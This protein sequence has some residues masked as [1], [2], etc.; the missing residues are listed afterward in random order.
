LTLPPDGLRIAILGA[1]STGKTTLAQA[2]VQRLRDDTGLRVAWIPEYLREWCER[3][4]RTPRPEEQAGIADEQGR[5]IDEAAG[6]H[7]VVLCDT[8]PLMVSVYS[9]FVF[10]DR[11]LHARA[12][13]WHARC[14]LTLV[15]ALD[16]PWQADG[17]QR[18]GPQVRVPVDGLVRAA[19]HDAG[20]GY[21]VV[22]GEGTARTD[23]AVA[24]VERALAPRPAAGPVWQ[25]H[26]ER[27]S[28]GDCERHAL[29]R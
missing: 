6:S 18:D 26:C 3:S 8:T 21:A 15:T 5:R 16:L 2:L 13:A 17:H 11:S 4:G 14:A 28:Q 9:E 23:A 1:E 27:C 12:L 25:W 19:L 7:D 20:I 29:R 22:S 10:G 24:A